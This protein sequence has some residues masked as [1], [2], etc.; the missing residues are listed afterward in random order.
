MFVCVPHHR[1]TVNLVEV[2]LSIEGT[3]IEA[4]TTPSKRPPE[5]TNT[6]TD[7]PGPSPPAQQGEPGSGSNTLASSVSN[8]KDLADDLAGAT[9][10]VVGEGGGDDLTAKRAYKARFMEGI[11]V[12]NK[13][14]KKGKA[15]H[16]VQ[17]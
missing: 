10:P 7:G 12:F 5:L 6:D 15:A 17:A 11:A 16:D 4:K 14:P 3:V 8:L 9:G 1:L 2:D 13:K